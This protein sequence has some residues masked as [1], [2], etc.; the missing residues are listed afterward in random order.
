[1]F[2]Y[3]KIALGFTLIELMIVVAI[4]GILAAIAYPSYTAYVARG[5]RAEAKQ[6]LLELAQFMERTY[7]EQNSYQ[8]GGASPVLPYTTMPKSGTTVYNLALDPAATS[9]TT[10]KLTATATGSMAN[11]ECGD[12]SIDNTGAQSVGGAATANAADCWNR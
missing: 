12:F 1:M 6:G 8:P 2:R 7:T 10:Y 11:D 4:I 9:A 5:H 3:N